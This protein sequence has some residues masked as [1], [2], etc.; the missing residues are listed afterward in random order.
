MKSSLKLGK[1]LF[2]SRE[3]EIEKMLPLVMRHMAQDLMMGMH[4]VDVVQDIAKAG[5]GPISE[6]FQMVSRDVKLG[7]PV[8]D[9]LID[10]QKRIKSRYVKRA[11]L[12]MI[13]AYE[14]EDAKPLLEI[15]K[16]MTDMQRTEIKEYSAK[17]SFYLVVMIATSAILPAFLAGFFSIGT[18]IVEMDFNP[19]NIYILFGVILPLI[20]F[21]M[22]YNMLKKAPRHYM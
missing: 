8:Q 6:E 22:L 1:G 13:T 20:N 12:Q 17:F 5:Y 7:K 14:T 9:A 11:I 21:L 10:M 15:A 4:F 18:I 19:M 3:G 2:Y 16:D